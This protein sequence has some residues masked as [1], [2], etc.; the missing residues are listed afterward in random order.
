MDQF[1]LTLSLVKHYVV[2]GD[3]DDHI[4][5]Y[6][7]GVIWMDCGQAVNTQHLSFLT[8]KCKSAINGLFSRLGYETIPAGNEAVTDLTENFPFMKN[9]F[10]QLRQWTIRRRVEE[11]SALETIR[12][13]V[14]EPAEVISLKQL[15]SRDLQT[16][17]STFH[18]SQS[19]YED[20]FDLG[21][22]NLAQETG[23]IGFEEFDF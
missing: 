2:R 22:G 17:S 15:G 5:G 11:D 9:N 19:W 14:T 3:S 13:A 23:S 18:P 7:C 4:R 8:A 6:V 21:F 10:G 20:G 1:Q 16:Q 12:T